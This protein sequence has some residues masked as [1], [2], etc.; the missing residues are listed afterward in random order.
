MAAGWKSGRSTPFDGEAFFTSAI[1]PARPASMLRRRL[2]SKPRRLPR[3]SLSPSTS[4]RR[5][6]RSRY[7]LAAA[8]SSAFTARILFRISDMMEPS[9]LLRQRQL[10]AEPDEQAA[11]GAVQPQRH[12]GF[13]LD[14]C[15]R[16][17]GEQR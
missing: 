12:G 4:R 14:A 3:S 2:A 6:Y 13:Q 9:G 16:A 8:T 10:D 1:T 17:G 11:G 7:F 15:A 5:L